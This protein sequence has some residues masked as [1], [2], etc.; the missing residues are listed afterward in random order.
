MEKSKQ[1]DFSGHDIFVGLDTHLKSWKTTV[2]VGSN[3]FKTFSQNPN[4]Q[5]L[6]D[7]STPKT[8]IFH[9]M[10]YFG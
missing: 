3:V 10:G 4:P 1:L 7:E 5:V 9:K 2:I 6:K 8:D